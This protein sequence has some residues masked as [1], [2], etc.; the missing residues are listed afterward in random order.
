[1]K[2]LIGL[3]G[4]WAVV[5]GC[6]A[7]EPV[8]LRWLADAPPSVEQGVTW[9][10]PWPEG[11]Y[12]PDTSFALKTAD[13]KT[14][15]VASWPLAYWPDGSLKWTAH[16]IGPDQ[17][18]TK[19]YVVSSGKPTAPAKPVVVK[20]GRSIVVDTGVVQCR[21]S[22]R[23]SNIIDVITRNGKEIIRNHQGCRADG[24][25]KSQPGQHIRGY[26]GFGHGFDNRLYQEG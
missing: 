2:K 23:G 14:I 9:G 21:F 26:S 7:V 8:E 25:Q 11:A 5:A 19:A 3:L 1:M 4:L 16:A 15:P 18:P 24:Y 20:D 13:D 10:V 6:Q 22:K 17:K 12:A